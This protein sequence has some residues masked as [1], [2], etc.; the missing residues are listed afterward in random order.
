[1]E[2]REITADEITAIDHELERWSKRRHRKYI[3]FTLSVLSSIPWIGG[4]FSAS[5]SFWAESDQ[6]RINELQ[7]LWLQ[8]HQRKLVDLG[9]DVD[10]IVQRFE[11]LGPAADERIEDP[12]Y[13]MLVEQAFRTWDKAATDE[14]RSLIKNTLSNAAGTS[15]CPDD[16]IRLFIEWID[17]YHEAHFAVI[18]QI[19]K[20]PGI[21]RGEI[22]ER[23]YGR[24]VRENSA[25]ADLFKLL[26]RDLSTGSVIRQHRETTGTG[27]FIRKQRPATRGRA[28]PLM[29]SAFDSQE[30]YELTELGK[31]FVHYAMTDVVPRIAGGDR[32]P[33]L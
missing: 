18:R 15:L 24:P 28:A 22:W 11:D 3:R 9:R 12:G 23:I 31:Q 10:E 25:E 17:Y 1:M 7:R 6:S 20:Q 4:F 32:E 8:E 33:S 14:K 27:E 26:I 5:A 2:D 30:P 29:K 19:Y 21:T 16:L 13:L